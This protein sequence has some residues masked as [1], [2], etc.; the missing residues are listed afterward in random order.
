MQQDVQRVLSRALVD[1]EFLNQMQTDP[2]A[3]LREFDLTDNERAVLTNPNRD[4]IELMR[5]GG[6]S[7]QPGFNIDITVIIDLTI[8]LSLDLTLDF[9]DVTLEAQLGK[10][11]AQIDALAE[12]ALQARSGADRLDSLQRLLENV[13]GAT[14]LAAREGGKGGGA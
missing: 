2:G 9:T 12:A 5:I 13:S 4:L 8:D 10:Q 6:S 1:D 3:A 14:R 11:R 7:T